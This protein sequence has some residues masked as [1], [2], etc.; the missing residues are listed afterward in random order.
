[1]I[2]FIFNLTR[3]SFHS[4]SD[5]LV[6]RLCVSPSCMINVYGLNVRLFGM[7]SIIMLLTRCR[8]SLAGISILSLAPQKNEAAWTRILVLLM[9]VKSVSLGFSASFRDLI[10][11][12]MCSIRYSISINGIQSTRLR[13]FRGVLE[14]DP[15]SPLLFILAQ[16][17]LS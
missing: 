10:Y 2:F 15:L 16:Q 12:H 13:S 11:R 4:L 14:G 17:V 9:N 1:M 3:N 8:G 6:N 7:I 5:T